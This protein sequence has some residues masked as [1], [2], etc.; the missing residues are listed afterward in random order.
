M[1]EAL[2]QDLHCLAPTSSQVPLDRVMLTLA[3]DGLP[4]GAG[5]SERSL[6][7]KNRLL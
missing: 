4:F 1:T 3:D 5:A 7:A 2:S 6:K